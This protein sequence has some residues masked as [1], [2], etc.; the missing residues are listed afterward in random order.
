MTGDMDVAR[1]TVHKGLSIS[2]TSGFCHFC[3]IKSEATPTQWKN[4]PMTKYW[5]VLK[6][7]VVKYEKNVKK[8]ELAETFNIHPDSNLF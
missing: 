4:K 2:Q 8:K 6:T 7:K 1:L 5:N 3:P